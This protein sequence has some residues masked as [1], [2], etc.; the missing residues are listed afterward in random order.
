MNVVRPIGSKTASEMSAVNTS[1][2]TPLRSCVTESSTS[3]R[4]I[5]RASSAYSAP[6]R[7]STT[8]FTLRTART[9]MTRALAH[10]IPTPMTAPMRAY[11]TCT[12]FVDVRCQKMGPIMTR[13]TIGSNNVIARG[14]TRSPLAS[15]TFAVF[16][17]PRRTSTAI[18]TSATRLTS[19]PAPEPFVEFTA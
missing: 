13:L 11:T 12:T 17:R 2:S 5:S 8:L 6:L 4:T 18:I 1:D 7:R 9:N 14:R 10:A 15:G 16:I 19:E 3:R